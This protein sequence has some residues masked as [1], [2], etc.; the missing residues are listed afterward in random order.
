MK[1]P[2]DGWEHTTHVRFRNAVLQ[3]EMEL[4]KSQ[5]TW[6]WKKRERD[7]FGEERFFYI[8]ITQAAKDRLK[9]VFQCSVGQGI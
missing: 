1:Y 9:S 4:K 8:Q 2:E 7:E 6:N 5:H 3:A